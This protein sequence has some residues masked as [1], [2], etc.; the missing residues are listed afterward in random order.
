MSL[1]QDL[2]EYDLI[3]CFDKGTYGSIFEAEHIETQIKYAI[4]ISRD[5]ASFARELMIYQT[6]EHPNIMKLYHWGVYQEIYFLIL[7]KGIPLDQAIDEKIVKM[8][9]LIGDILNSV[10]FLHQNG[11]FHGDIKFDNFVY[12]DGKAMLID[13]GFSR[14][15]YFDGSR[16][17]TGGYGG[18]Q[19][20]SD[21]EWSVL[22]LNLIESELFGIASAIYELNMG[23]SRRVMGYFDPLLIGNFEVDLLLKDLTHRP[24]KERFPLSDLIPLHGYKIVEGSFNSKREPCKR[25]IQYNTLEKVFYGVFTSNFSNDLLFNWWENFLPFARLSKGDETLVELKSLHKIIKERR[26]HRISILSTLFHHRELVE[27]S[28]KIIVDYLKEDNNGKE[29]LSI[30]NGN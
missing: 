12:L 8:N 16:Y 4:K 11:I 20:S 27:S 18:S 21:P 15:G 9:D 29:F 19:Y 28:D 24:V 2:S 30:I 23:V 22:E 17:Y 25:K 7:P 26:F 5:Q 10:N 1:L 13:F 6:C 3:S 14:L